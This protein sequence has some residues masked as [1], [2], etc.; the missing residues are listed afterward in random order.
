VGAKAR[1]EGA[2]AGE[3]ASF[4]ENA[5]SISARERSTKSTKDT[6]YGVGM[7]TSVAIAY[8]V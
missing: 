1:V 2:R 8:A 7:A 6:K 3:D 5:G 4:R